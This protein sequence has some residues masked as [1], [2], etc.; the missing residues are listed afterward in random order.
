MAKRYLQLLFDFRLRSFIYFPGINAVFHIDVHNN[1]LHYYAGSSILGSATSVGLSV[2]LIFLIFAA[3]FSLMARGRRGGARGRGRGRSRAQREDDVEMATSDGASTPTLGHTPPRRRQPPSPDLTSPSTRHITPGTRTRRQNEARVVAQRLAAARGGGRRIPNPAPHARRSRRV[4]TMQLLGVLNK[5]MLAITDLGI[6]AMG[7]HPMYED[8][9]SFVERLGNPSHVSNLSDEDVD[10]LA[11]MDLDAIQRDLDAR[12]EEEES[13]SLHGEGDGTGSQPG[14]QHKFPE[15]RSMPKYYNIGSRSKTCSKCG[16][17]LWS[18]EK[19]SICCS[20][21]AALSQKD[22]FS[23]PPQPLLQLLTDPSNEGKAFRMKIRQ[24]NNSLAMASSG[25]KMANPPGFSMLAV[26]G[27]AH[28]YV[29]P[30]H[31]V[32]GE[33]ADRRFAQLY[34]IDTPEREVE[35]RVENS[36]RLGVSWTAEETETLRQLQD[37]LHENNPL[38]QQYKQMCD[39]PVS[40]VG[41]Y[42]FV[43]KTNGIDKRRYNAPVAAEVAGFMP[44]GEGTGGHREFK[45]RCRD[46]GSNVWAMND[47]HPLCDPMRF[48]LFHPRGVIILF[49]FPIFIY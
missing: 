34:I 13:Q 40:E 19:D 27:G 39:F 9:L 23:E 17:K 30:P 21:G 38:V 43:F 2:L 29:A 6:V 8:L 25:M 12:V 42:E 15:E 22:R 46:G 20:G 36:T 16:A 26:R 14:R 47:M 5:I 10:E 7:C 11:A 28:H 35:I 44:G 37:M 33:D 24:M 3:V 1:T 32:S 45:V 49:I 4:Q 48:V 18:K 31:P 41:N